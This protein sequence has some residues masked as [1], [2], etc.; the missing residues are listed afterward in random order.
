[1]FIKILSVR[2][3]DNENILENPDIFANLEEQFLALGEDLIYDFSSDEII[4]YREKFLGNDAISF[5]DYMEE[6]KILKNFLL[7][8]NLATEENYKNFFSLKKEEL[9]TAEKQQKSPEELDKLIAKV[10]KND[11]KLLDVLS[12]IQKIKK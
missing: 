6:W 7:E 10:D 4:V 12:K 1:M 8:N 5:V 3:A 2:F 9:T 11:P